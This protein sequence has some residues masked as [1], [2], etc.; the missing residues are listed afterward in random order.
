MI[1][2]ASE[3]SSSF[4]I[5]CVFSGEVEFWFW[6]TEGAGRVSVELDSAFEV[7]MVAVCSRAAVG[8]EPEEVSA[9][10]TTLESRGIARKENRY[11]GG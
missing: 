10:A 9:M 5:T 3:A 6:S 7:S 1:S 2:S 11:R 4:M 8:G